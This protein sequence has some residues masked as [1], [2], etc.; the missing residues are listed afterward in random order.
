MVS[1]HAVPRTS[2]ARCDKLAGGTVAVPLAALLLLKMRGTVP[3]AFHFKDTM[4]CQLLELRGAVERLQ[5]KL[6]GKGEVPTVEKLRALKTVLQSPLFHRILSMQ[7]PGRVPPASTASCS[8]PCLAHSDSYEWALRIP[9]YPSVPAAP[10][11][12]G[13]LS[14]ARLQLVLQ[15]TAQGRYVTQIEL[16]R[17]VA[18]ELGLGLGAVESESTEEGGI[19][20][21]EILPGGAVHREGNLKE[22]DRILAI[23]GQP[24]D[25]ACSLQRAED[26]LENAPE[27]V[28]LIVARGPIQELDSPEMSVTRSSANALLPCHSTNDREVEVIELQNSGAGLGFGIVGKKPEGVVV[29]TILPG[30]TADKDG[31]LR[32]GD[33]LLQIGDTDV[34]GLSSEEV[35]CVLQQCGAQVRLLISRGVLDETP[36]PSLAA[37][38]DAKRQ[39]CGDEETDAFDVE[40]TKNAEGLGITIAGYIGEKNAEPSGIFV[41]SIVKDSAVEL[42][43]RIHVGDQIIAVDGTNIQGYSNE[44]A[45]ELL[46]HTGQTV[47]L[48]LVR[49]GSQPGQALTISAPVTVHRDQPPEARK[50]LTVDR[51]GVDTGR[52]PKLTEAEEEELKKK[53][54]N[55]VGLSNE[56]MVAQVE[57]F[58]ECSG[59]GVSLEARDADPGRH[60][61]CS[62]LPEGPVGR[63]GNILAGD[64]LLEVNGI[65]LIGET[66]KE[67][68]GILKEL[69]MCVY[70]VCCRPA[71]TALSDSRSGQSR[72][73]SRKAIS[74]EK[75]QGEVEGCVVH[76]DGSEAL[77]EHV[78][79][80]SRGS[81]LAMW[82]TER[83]VLELEKGDAGLGFSILDYQDPLDPEKTVTVIRSL[84]PG[85]VAERDGRLLPG[86][87]LMSVN[88]A[89]LGSSSLEEAV[90]ALKGAGRGPVRIGVAKPLPMD[91]YDLDLTNE[92]SFDRNHDTPKAAMLAP[93]SSNCTERKEDRTRPDPGDPQDGD[94]PTATSGAPFQRTITVAKGNSSLGM[95]VSAIKDGSGMV[96]RS[97]VHGGSISRDGRLAVG[98]CILAINGEPTVNLTNAQGRALLRRQSLIGPDISIAYVPA[99]HLKEYRASLRLPAQD[100]ITEV[101]APPTLRRKITGVTK[102]EHKGGEDPEPHGVDRDSWNQPRKVE[103]H[104][105]CGKSLGIS[106]MGGRGMGSRLSNGEV[107]RGIFIK[108]IL[109]D[110]PAGRDGTLKPGDRIV[111]VGGVD[112]QDA[113]HEEAVEAIR[114]AGDPV[115]FCVQD[116]AQ[117]PTSPSSDLSEERVLVTSNTT[118]ENKVDIHKY[119]LLYPPMTRQF[120]LVPCRGHTSLPPAQ[121]DCGKASALVPPPVRL[122]VT[123][124]AET[125]DSVTEAEGLSRPQAPTLKALGEEEEDQF[126]YSWRKIMDRY[127]SLPGELHVLEVEKGA[128]GLGLSLRGSSDRGR[129]SVFVGALEPGGAAGRGGRIAP[130]DELLEINGQILYG[131]SQQ[132]ASSIIDRAPSKVKIIFIRNTEPQKQMAV[133]RGYGDEPDSQTELDQCAVISPSAVNVDMFKYVQYVVLPRE[134]GG[135]GL[136]LSEE[137]TGDGVVIQSLSEH[138]TAKKDGRIRPGDKILSL[139]DETVIGLPVGQVAGLLEK[140]RRRVKLALCVDH[141]APPCLSADSFHPQ[142]PRQTG[143]A[144]AHPG[145]EPIRSFTYTSMTSDPVTCP[146]TPGCEST[147]ELSKGQT[148]LGLSIVGGSDTL[149]GV[150]VIHEIYEE[151][152]AAK[153][154]RLWAGDQ[155]LEVNGVDLRTATHDEAMSVLRQM[156]QRVRL[157]VWREGAPY[158]EEDLWDVFALELRTAPGQG[159]G[160]GVVGK[161]C[162]A[163]PEHLLRNDTGVFVSDTAPGSAS[164]A[165]GRLWPG[166]QILSVNGEDVRAATQEHVATLLQ[167]YAGSVCLEVARFKA[168]PCHSEKRPSMCSQVSDVSSCGAVLYGSSGSRSLQGESDHRCRSDNS[169][170]GYPEI[171]FPKIGDRIVSVCGMPTEGLTRDQAGTL[172]GNTSDHVELQVVGGDSSLSG[173]AEEEVNTHM[174]HSDRGPAQYKRITLDRGSD[175]LGFS[176]VGGFGSPHGDLPI[177]VKTVFSKGAAAE[178]GRL[179]RG[180]QVLAVNGLPL[181]GVTHQEAV[182]ILKRTRGAV[183]LTVLSH[184]RDFNL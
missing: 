178:D 104:R 137:D 45:V 145:T 72:L 117:S 12:R 76:C 86:D 172:L 67:V 66:H 46:R 33:R 170:D 70:V 95:T 153:D 171:S 50:G 123:P 28:Q 90:R 29:K 21:Q 165:D 177:Y 110:S 64:Q 7:T 124:L 19:F 108:H 111:E 184:S 24:L 40:L 87:R 43:G 174:F 1:D 164:E 121:R 135:F 88:D 143:S 3:V 22:G 25:Q 92:T 100:D 151:G 133:G 69:P 63:S 182:E 83:Q 91:Y 127:G 154:G 98:D 116:V 179:Q 85:G 68:V 16:P 37:T 148:G 6:R 74:A 17:P 77:K 30:G 10:V 38:P 105:E 97:I 125:P 34:S 138:G 101:D 99:E 81:P 161:R 11:S 56:I 27:R 54:E 166:D 65:S 136:N 42:D 82:E 157:T 61:I 26:M 126:G 79:E 71:Q 128:E 5:A 168:G 53:W 4:N 158:R 113:S 120:T 180:D 155:I 141:T 112:L 144:P 150:T 31:R 129:M 58:S 119:C 122:S 142:P 107:M 32:R 36:C 146:I 59:L 102:P 162:G 57:K 160:L 78:A 84:V 39:G 149:L 55:T 140:A 176:I 41:K 18:G 152:A 167:G 115:V 60:Y 13:D 163:A 62:V 156:P 52:G 134:P 48:E 109:E 20:V 75:E 118:A 147:I 181:E 2:V 47:S 35:A 49:W 44:Q 103:L 96:V 89:D 131:R 9:A 114:K 51:M 175:G 106:I 23:D 173:Y 94:K 93:R 8:L 73:N 139:D 15:A 169:S 14:A 80:E 132:N 130:G 183:S 159:L